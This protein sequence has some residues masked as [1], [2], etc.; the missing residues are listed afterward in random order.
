MRR[1][2]REEWPVAET[3]FQYYMALRRIGFFPREAFRLVY[4]HFAG[5]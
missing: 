4:G 5:R 1:V 3:P 2:N